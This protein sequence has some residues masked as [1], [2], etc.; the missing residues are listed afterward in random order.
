MQSQC[1]VKENSLTGVK[2]YSR[3]YLK[4]IEMVVELIVSKII[5][6]P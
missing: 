5:K 6:P 1:K 3:D 2:E 4:E